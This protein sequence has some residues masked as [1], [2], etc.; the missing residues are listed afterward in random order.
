MLFVIYYYHV[1]HKYSEKV[2]KMRVCQMKLFLWP[3]SVASE[4]AEVQKMARPSIF[5]QKA[6]LY[7]KQL[8]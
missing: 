7:Q 2:N 6:A 1:W 8:Q 4:T 5:K 3:F